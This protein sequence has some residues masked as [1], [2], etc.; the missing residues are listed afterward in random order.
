[1]TKATKYHVRPILAA[2]ALLA[3][4]C[5][6]QARSADRA[7]PA[8]PKTG[9]AAAPTAA[10]VATVGARKITDLDIRRA[11]AALDDDPLHKRDPAAWRRM[12][13]DRC[14]DRE[15]LAMEADRHGLDK[16]PA[17]AARIAE[18]EFLTLNRE[19]YRRVILPGVIPT[20]EQL[21][22]VRAEGLHRMVDISFI[23]LRDHEK[24][25]RLPLAQR[26]Y[27]SAKAGARFDSLAKIYDDHPPTRATGGHFGWVLARDINP[28]AHDAL[29]KAQVGDVIGVFSGAVG[30]EIYKIGGLRELP[31]DSLYDL[32]LLE[33]KSNI[34]KDYEKS[35]LAKYHFAMDSTQVRALVFAAG[36]ES[37]D[38]ILASLGPDGTRSAEGARPAIGIL[39]RCDGDSVT[40]PEIIR[41]MP[42]TL[43]KGSRLRIRNADD[44]HELCV[45]AVLRGLTVRDAKDR[46]IDKD[47]ETARELR[48]SRAQ[49][50]TQAMV[51]R[52]SPAPDDATLRAMV[53]ARPDRYRRPRATVAR[54]AMFARRD[55]AVL[56]DSAWAGT[57]MSDSLLEVWQFR[58]DPHA[59]PGSIYGGWY[60]TMTV[61]DG[62]PEALARA[63]A[64]VPVG[65]L[66]P[67]VA[68][69]RGWAVARVISREGPRPLT[70]DEAAPLALREWRDDAENKW[71]LQTLER[72][73]AKTPVRAVPGRLAAV[74]LASA[75]AASSSTSTTMRESSR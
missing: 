27:Q 51:E 57:E 25:A 63:L 15:L 55:S 58:T 62:G 53:E 35:V 24:G 48:L 54:V 28:M 64:D 31:D 65:Q 13:L 42:M 37:A 21:R 30:H 5:A 36:S 52:S 17:I 34:A 39:A 4:A 75:T 47:F 74:K 40:F 68:T 12:L 49:I 8:S 41:A 19:M 9:A 43:R 20:P 1:M 3:L 14:V 32:V 18:R 67:V 11:A 6:G 69:E 29:R 50:L 44:F 66:T 23:V 7:A 60:A 38:S 72:L 45:R 46:G 2:L 26:V 16:D 73:R 71:V 59:A 22:E 33:R 56:A 61:L 70:F 10:T